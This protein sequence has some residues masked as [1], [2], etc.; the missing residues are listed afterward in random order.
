M[1]IFLF[2]I[3]LFLVNLFVFLINKDF[4]CPKK[5]HLFAF[6]IVEIMIFFLQEFSLHSLLFLILFEIMII[7]SFVDIVHFEINSKMYWVLFI[8]CLIQFISS[9]SLVE[10]FLSVF[11]VYVTFW[12][13]DKF[14]GI[15]K[16]GGADVKIML[17]LS[18]YFLASEVLL[19]V[20]LVFAISAVIF[21]LERIV[22]KTSC[23][24][25]VPM[26]AAMSIAI[27]IQKFGMYCF[28]FI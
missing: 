27:F 14:V 5:Y 4:K 20:L 3:I 9:I 21:I 18:F 6:L 16:L 1:N 17:I 10:S 23:D 26:V 7:L 2:S 12:I 19:F 28:N 13:F 25:Q 24:L 8:P 22:K 15:E 11:A